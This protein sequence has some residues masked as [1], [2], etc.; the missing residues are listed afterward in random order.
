MRIISQD[1]NHSVSFENTYIWKQYGCIYAYVGKRDVVLGQYES[2]ERAQ[3]VFE[4][5]HCG[6]LPYR[7]PESYSQAGLTVVATMLEA[8][9]YCLPDK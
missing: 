6:H 8:T 9:C 7:K 4:E 3:E 2:K 5:I 1:K